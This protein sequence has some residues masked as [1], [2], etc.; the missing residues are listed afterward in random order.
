MSEKVEMRRDES[1]RIYSV[2]RKQSAFARPFEILGAIAVYLSILAFIFGV[3]SFSRPEIITAAIAN[4][5][6]LFAVL[7]GAGVALVAFI[8]QVKS[9]GRATFERGS[10]PHTRVWSFGNLSSVSKWV[11]Q[12]LT[13]M[14]F[15]DVN[16]GAAK[17][18][19]AGVKDG[20]GEDSKESF[21][22]YGAVSSGEPFESYCSSI[23]KSLS[24]YATSSEETATKLLDKGVAFM[25][26]GLVFY[27]LAIV[28]WQI[29]AN[30]THPDPHVMYVGMAACS[31]TFVVVEF[32]AAWF[33][34]QYR[35]YVEVSMT[36]LRV[37]SG[38]DRYLLGYYA[39]REFKGEADQSLRDQMSAILK[40]DVKWPTY[41]SGAANDFN[42]MME[43]MNASHTTLEKMKDLFQPK[44]TKPESQEA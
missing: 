41:K 7:F 40:E 29:F 22:S 43:S 6:A 5:D 14:E 3:L 39:L 19:S 26:G 15:T 2:R 1:G 17:K 16:G 30:L 10:Y 27:I 24:A 23:L 11:V 21:F 38:Y 35:Y 8:I 12:T 34:K 28:V 31:M 32:L 33:F 4:K 13:G 37:R 25:A 42:Y 36:C 9:L 44:K 18:G 20:I